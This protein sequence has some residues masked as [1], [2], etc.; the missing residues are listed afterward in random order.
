[1]PAVSVVVIGYNDAEHLPQALR[2]ATRQSLRDIEIVVVDDGSSDRS[3][4]LIDELAAH[5][6]RVVPVRLEGNSGGCSVPRN[7][8]VAVASGDGAS[9]AEPAAMIP[10]SFVV[11][12]TDEA[13]LAANRLASPCLAPEAPHELISVLKTGSA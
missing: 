5:D 12:V 10:L 11:C 4:M 3:P 13:T 9:V 2:S 6:R 1:M 8:G 7:A